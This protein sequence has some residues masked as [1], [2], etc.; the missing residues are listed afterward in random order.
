MHRS[1]E[2]T[3]RFRRQAYKPRQRKAKSPPPDGYL[4]TAQ[5]AALLG[6]TA[7]VLGIHRMVR[8]AWLPSPTHNP[9]GLGYCLWWPRDATLAAIAR[10]KPRRAKGW[11]PVPD[12]D[13]HATVYVGA[14]GWRPS[15]VHLSAMPPN[16]REAS[17][18]GDAVELAIRRHF[19]ALVFIDGPCADGEHDLRVP[20]PWDRD[21]YRY[22]RPRRVAVA[23][24]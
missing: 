13:G 23:A 20:H 14:F 11:H 17:E 16:P 19:G 3:N 2:E 15:R 10:G 7:K 21:E 4:T 6:V 24:R 18:I 22:R 8:Y 5:V 9:I 12:T 1:R